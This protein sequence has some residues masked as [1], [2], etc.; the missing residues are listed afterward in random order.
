MLIS[1]F[2]SLHLHASFFELFV[3]SADFLLL[4]LLLLWMQM[5]KKHISD[6]SMSGERPTRQLVAYAPVDNKLSPRA[7]QPLVVVAGRSR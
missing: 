2:W 5:N 7:L 1:M 3:C 4:L 6:S